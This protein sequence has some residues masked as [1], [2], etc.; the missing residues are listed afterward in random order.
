MQDE[1]AVDQPCDCREK[2]R[3]QVRRLYWAEREEEKLGVLIRIELDPFFRPRESEHR[4]VQTFETPVGNGDPFPQ[5][6]RTPRGTLHQRGL[7][8]AR[9]PSADVS[10]TLAGT[11][12]LGRAIIE[13][14]H[15]RER[16]DRK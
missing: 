1:F 15:A 13:Q 10:D 12:P 11:P 14:L 3:L 16:W 5:I 4:L 9:N 8:C 2:T 6:N 7:H